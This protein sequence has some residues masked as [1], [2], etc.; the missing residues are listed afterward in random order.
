MGFMGIESI[1]ESD[2]TFDYMCELVEKIKKS[3][4]KQML[5]KT[6]EYNTSG[7][8]DA[9]LVLKSLISEDNEF[10]FTN[11]L[12]FLEVWE[13]LGLVLKNPN[14]GYKQ[15][16]GYEKLVEFVEKMSKLC[17]EQEEDNK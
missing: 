6:N 13:P 10:Y 16:E 11:D 14:C 9:I 15:M 2:C 3:I 4:K 7:Y 8:I 17:L 12:W 5:V 1:G